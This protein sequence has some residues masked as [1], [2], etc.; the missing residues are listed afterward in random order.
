[1]GSGQLRSGA[2]GDELTRVSAVTGYS[3]SGLLNQPSSGTVAGRRGACIPGVRQAGVERLPGLAA[4]ANP[5][6]VALLLFGG[7]RKGI[8]AL[9]TYRGRYRGLYRGPW[10]ANRSHLRQPR[11][12]RDPHKHRVCGTPQSSAINGRNWLPHFCQPAGFWRRFTDDR[13]LG[14]SSVN[15]SHHSACSKDL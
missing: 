3:L 5:E 1:V 14:L 13:I 9:K 2:G 6:R 12:A 4:R 15:E 8:E 11:S 7:A 10:A